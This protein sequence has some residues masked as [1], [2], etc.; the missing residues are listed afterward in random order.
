MKEKLFIRL[1]QA[2]VE[3]E[4]NLERHSKIFLAAKRK[5]KKSLPSRKKEKLRILL[6]E[7]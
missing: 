7:N 1:T 2:E 6:L 4:N 3:M 5:K